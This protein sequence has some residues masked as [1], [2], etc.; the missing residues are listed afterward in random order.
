MLSE[1]GAVEAV[2]SILDTFERQGPERLATLAA[3]VHGGDGADMARAAHVFRGAAATIG[4]GELA[5]VLEHVETAARAGDLE[6]AR[7]A[8]E[9]A[10]GAAHAVFDYLRRERQR[11][12]AAA[13]GGGR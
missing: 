13:P 7:A 3:A 8:F 2:D 10:H 12:R 11:A 4:A 9:H 1:A 6:A 5:G